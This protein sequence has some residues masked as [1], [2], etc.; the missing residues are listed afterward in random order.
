MKF[1]EIQ[2]QKM[3]VLGIQGSGKTYYAKEMIKAQKYKTLIYAPHKADY[4][5][6]P[7]NCQVIRWRNFIK[8]FEPFCELAIK[9]AKM[10][11][12]DGIYVD[13]LDMLVRN[14]YDIGQHFNDIILN[15][16][17]YPEGKGM[18]FVGVT[19]RP[20]DVPAKIF[21][22]TA[23]IVAF[24]IEAPNA[25]NKLNQIRAGFGD[26]IAYLNKKR[27]EHYVKEIGKDPVKYD[28]NNQV[29]HNVS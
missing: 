2:G 26:K 27:H 11:E 8:D 18:F 24:A 16:R 19:R 4:T 1:P 3:I 20:Q 17:H 9:L 15:H 5:D 22:S 21:E 10:G 29:V 12:I 7:K 14:N 28:K 6:M 25:K 13:E 23:Y